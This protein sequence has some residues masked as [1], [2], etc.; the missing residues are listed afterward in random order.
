MSFAA[1]LEWVE[2][3]HKRIETEAPP[4]SPQLHQCR[5]WACT[6]GSEVRWD[7]ARCPCCLAVR[8]IVDDLDG[9]PLW[10]AVDP[11]AR[12]LM[13]AGWSMEAAEEA[14][15]RLAIQGEGRGG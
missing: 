11:L 13:R 8:P 5:W 4:P 15:E 2:H 1:A 7:H 14:V 9:V 3:R 6:C 10:L 12:R